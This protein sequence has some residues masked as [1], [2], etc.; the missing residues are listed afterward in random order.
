VITVLMGWLVLSEPQG[1]L[2]FVA[3]IIIITGVYLSVAI[4][5]N[6]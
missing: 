4:R 3:M 1:I 5:R 2:Q 6:P